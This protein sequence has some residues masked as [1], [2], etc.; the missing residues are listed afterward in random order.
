[1]ATFT[2]CLLGPKLYRQH[3]NGRTGQGADYIP[4]PLERHSDRILGWASVMW[5]I[6]YYSCPFLMLTAYRKGHFFTMNYEKVIETSGYLT[7]VTIFLVGV[8]CARGGYFL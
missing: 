8:F 7:C 3:R 6:T 1:M 4:H 5:S 2:R